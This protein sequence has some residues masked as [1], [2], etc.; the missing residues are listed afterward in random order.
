MYNVVF[1][2]DS[3]RHHIII[4]NTKVIKLL[5]GKEENKLRSEDGTNTDNPL[6]THNFTHDPNTELPLI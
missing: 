4:F 5:R 2:L 6:I 3:Y 1:T